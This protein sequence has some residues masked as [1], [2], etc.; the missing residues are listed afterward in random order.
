MSEMTPGQAAYEAHRASWWKRHGMPTDGLLPDGQW[1]QM[2]GVQGGQEDWEAVAQAVLKAGICPH[3]DL[4]QQLAAA[5]AERDKAYS[6]RARLVA[7]LAACYPSEIVP[8]ESDSGAWFLVFVTTPAG[9]MSWHLHEDDLDLF[10]PLLNAPETGIEWDGHSTEQKYE[11]LAELTDRIA[12]GGGFAGVVAAVAT[13]RPAPLADGSL[14]D[15]K[16]ATA[17]RDKYRKLLDEIG[18][19]AA[20]APED[21]DSFGLLEEIAMRIAAAGVPDSTPIGE[22]PDPDNPVTGRTPGAAAAAES[23][24]DALEAQS[25]HDSPGEDL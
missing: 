25:L 2:S 16:S 1:E 8:A 10:E 11:R 5:E 6:E 3:G 14:N 19:T 21:G 23:A 20:N 12:R 7:Y 22:R 15:L 24:R 18:V 17:E 9:Q 4:A 13:A